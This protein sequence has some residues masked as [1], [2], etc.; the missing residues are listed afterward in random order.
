ME[1]GLKA[2]FKDNGKV[3]FTK[4]NSSVT[5]R[6]RATG[7]LFGLAGKAV[8]QQTIAAPADTKESPMDVRSISTGRNGNCGLATSALHRLQSLP[9]RSE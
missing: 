1:S 5:L 9:L 2:E 7:S 6:G 3:L 8:V 4:S